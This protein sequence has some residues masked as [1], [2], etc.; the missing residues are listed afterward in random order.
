VERPA[1]LP[2]A[3]V[4]AYSYGR[5]AVIEQF[6][7]GLEV[8]VAVIETADGPQALPPVA[9]RPDSGVYDYE[10]RYTAGATKFVCPADLPA[11]V[12]ARCVEVALTAH[13]VLHLRDISRTDLIVDDTGE[14][15][16]LEGN[17]APGMT[18]TSTVPLAI[19][20]AGFDF[21]QVLAQLVDRAWSRVYNA[22]R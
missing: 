6:I 17:V 8:A 18:D 3:M 9:I 14:P 19:E 5:M 16:F 13:R 20:T 15:V 12:T 10:S 4:K 22:G 21:G 2:A 11:A 7:S 1:D